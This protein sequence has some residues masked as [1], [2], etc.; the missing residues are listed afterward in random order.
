MFVSVLAWSNTDTISDITVFSYMWQFCVD[1]R[2]FHHILQSHCCIWSFVLLNFQWGCDSNALVDAE[3]ILP[4]IKSF[5]SAHTQ[6]P[7]YKASMY[8]DWVSMYMLDLFPCNTIKMYVSF[9]PRL[10]SRSMAE[11]WVRPRNK[12][13][14]MRVLLLNRSFYRYDAYKMAMWSKCRMESF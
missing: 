12:T 1:P 11:R 4:C 13:R 5:F 6:E 10:S 3:G 7:G 2:W 9:V 8:S 14:S